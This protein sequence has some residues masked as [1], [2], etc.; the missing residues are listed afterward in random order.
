[1]SIKSSQT[2]VEEAK[3]SIETL[4]SDEVKQLVEKNQITLI[5]IRD[6]R[7]LWKEG[8][9]ENSKHIPRGMLEFW[10]DPESSYYKTNKIKDMKKM[11]LFCALGF[12]S[13]LATKSLKDM[14]FKNVAHV[15]GGFDALKNSGLSVISKEKK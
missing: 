5:D 12:R 13:A 1:M 15:D 6:I 3:K 2:L 7:E 4:N 14:G 11:V 9:I 10:L 8:T